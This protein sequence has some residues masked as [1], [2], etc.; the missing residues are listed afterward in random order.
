MILIMGTPRKGTPDFR[1][2][3]PLA[4]LLFLLLQFLLFL[5]HTE[6]QEVLLELLLAFK[7]RLL[8]L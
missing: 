4:R 6:L 1:K 7:Q 8:V 5:V 2:P 3:L